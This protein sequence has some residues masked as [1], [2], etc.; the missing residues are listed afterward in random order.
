MSRKRRPLTTPAFP[1]LRAQLLREAS[2]AGLIC[3]TARLYPAYLRFRERLDRRA[4][5]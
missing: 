2:G 4:G 5:R 1:D 3:P